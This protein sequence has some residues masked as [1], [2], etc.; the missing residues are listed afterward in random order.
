MMIKPIIKIIKKNEKEEDYYIISSYEKEIFNRYSLDEFK[1]PVKKWKI[2]LREYYN[3]LEKAKKIREER[4]RKF[5][6]LLL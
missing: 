5:T 4:Y 3:I 2:T 6:N 1:N